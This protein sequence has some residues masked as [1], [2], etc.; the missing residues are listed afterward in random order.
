LGNKFL[1][2]CVREVCHLWAQTVFNTFHQICIIA[3]VLWSKSVLQ[4]VKQMAVARNDIRALR[5]VVR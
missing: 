2:A 5:K 1:Y 4:V 3:E